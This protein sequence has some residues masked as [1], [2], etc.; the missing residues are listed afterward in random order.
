[1]L[2]SAGQCCPPR[3][4]TG[5]GAS[6]RSTSAPTS[7][8]SRWPIPA[9]SSGCRPIAADPAISV[10]AEQARAFPPL[11]CSAGGDGRRSSPTSCWSALGPPADPAACCTSLVSAC[12]DVDLVNDIEAA[13]TQIRE[14]AALLGHPER[15]EALIA[16]IDAARRGSRRRR[17]RAQ[18]NGAAGRQRRGYTVGPRKPRR[19]AAARGRLDA[20]GRRARRLSAAT[21]R[22]RS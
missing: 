21:C 18:R 4:P 8:S 22:S 7:L 6:P 20:A 16:E 15:G 13:R 9:R 17:G 14:V 5:R 2:F 11:A 19:R 1:M 12:V 3:P 10:V